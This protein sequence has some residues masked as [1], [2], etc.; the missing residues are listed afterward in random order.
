MNG[1]TLPPS[2]RNDAREQRRR[3]HAVDVVVAVDENRLAARGS[4]ARGARRR[5]RD[6]GAV[7]A[8]GAGRAAAADSAWRTPRATCPR[9]ASSRQIGSGRQQLVAEAAN[10]AR[11]RCLREDPARARTGDGCGRGHASEARP[12]AEAEQRSARRHSPAYRSAPHPS[13]ISS[14]PEAAMTARRCVG[15]ARVARAARRAAQRKDASRRGGASEPCRTWRASRA[16]RRAPFRSRLARAWRDL[17]LDLGALGVERRRARRT[18]GARRRRARSRARP[19]WWRISPMRPRI[20]DASRSL[21]SAMRFVCSSCA[22]AALASRGDVTLSYCALAALDE[23]PVRLDAGASPR[24]AAPRRPR[25]PCA[26]APAPARR[27]RARFSSALSRGASAA[28]R[29]LE[30]V[31][32]EIVLLHGEQRLNVRMHGRADRR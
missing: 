2:A 6:R 9:A 16:A 8:G 23:L 15:I 25:R 17:A 3:A 1:T 11:I 10:D 4:R 28:S 18:G 5:G 7:R 31:D 22:M 14:V 32:L 19:T 26:A 29:D 21:S 20:C 12:R 30:R 24:D 13:H 27:G